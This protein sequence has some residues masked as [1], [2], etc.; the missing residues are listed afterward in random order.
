MA[1]EGAFVE[2]VLDGNTFQ[3]TKYT[4]TLSGVY[5]PPLTIPEGREAKQKLVSKIAKRSVTYKITGKADY[6]V[7]LAEVWVDDLNVNDWMR[8][9]GYNKNHDWRLGPEWTPFQDG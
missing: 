2:N 5:V 7:R 3:T 9:Q 1:Y 4:I 8:K 6:G